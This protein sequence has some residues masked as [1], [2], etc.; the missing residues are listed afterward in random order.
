MLF[1]SGTRAVGWL[2]YAFI[3]LA[4]H[5]LGYAWLDGKLGGPTRAIMWGGGALVLLLVLVMYG[6]YPLSMVSV[7]GVDISNSLPPKFPMLL[8]GIAQCGLLLAL[9]RPARRWLSNL[10]LWTT[11]VLINGMIM[12]VFLWHLTA[13]MLVIA[14]TVLLLGSVGLTVEPGSGIWWLLRPVWLSI[15]AVALMVFVLVFLRF[16]RGARSQPIPAW[17]QVV[18]ATLVCGGLSLLALMGIGGEGRVAL[19]I[20]VVLMPFLGAAIAGVNPLSK[21]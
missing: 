2:N 14:V 1:L 4:V 21:G 8:L 18:G 3:W 12:T 16:E 11:A 13:S 15:Y 7:P 5:K 10:K 19:S 17:R 9:E 6:P 20:C